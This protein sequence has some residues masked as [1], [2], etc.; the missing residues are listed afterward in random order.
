MRPLSGLAALALLAAPAAGRSPII[1]PKPPATAERL[2][3]GVT[4]I[5]GIGFAYLPASLAGPAPLLLLFHGAG[6]SARPFVDGFKREGNRCGCVLLAVQSEGP[7]WDL[8]TAATRGVR[9]G[10]ASVDRLFG[11]DADRVERGIAELM[12]RAPIDR[13][14]IVP[15][16]FSDGASFALTLALFN[17]ALFRSAIAIAPGFML[18]PSLIDPVQRIFVAHGRSD[19]ILP[20]AGTEANVV[21]PLRNAGYRLIF[22]PFEGGHVID[23]SSLGAGIAY[24]LGRQG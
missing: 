9:S 20:F 13:A 11:A 24:A 2:K 22:R 19:R 17:P 16:G 5:S 15:I 6:M 1:D 12:A 18:Q 23:R 21:L 10:S 8:V 3:S 4:E 14:R 7:T